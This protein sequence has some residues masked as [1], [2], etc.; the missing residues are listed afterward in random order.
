MNRTE[1]EAEMLATQERGGAN[2]ATVSHDTTPFAK[3]TTLADLGLTRGQT[4]RDQ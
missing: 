1:A 3:P 4:Q 2:I